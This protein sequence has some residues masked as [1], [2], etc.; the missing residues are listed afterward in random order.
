MHDYELDESGFED[1]ERMQ[2]RPDE[3]NAVLLPV[4]LVAGRWAEAVQWASDTAGNILR[5]GKIMIPHQIKIDDQSTR[6]VF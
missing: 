3:V 2:R 4:W 5:L 1:V 6:R